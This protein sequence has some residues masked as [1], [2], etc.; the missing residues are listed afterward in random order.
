MSSKSQITTS[1]TKNLLNVYN[2]K[3]IS[4]HNLLSKQYSLY[5]IYYQRIVGC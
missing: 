4:Q 1:F 3:S 2:V 5:E